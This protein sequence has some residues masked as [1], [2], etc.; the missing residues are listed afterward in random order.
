MSDS[1]KRLTKQGWLGSMCFYD[2][3]YECRFILDSAF[4]SSLSSR[5]RYALCQAIKG[6]GLK[7]R[8]EII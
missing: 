7:L 8:T 5:V 3:S 6:I 1:E 2:G 4:T